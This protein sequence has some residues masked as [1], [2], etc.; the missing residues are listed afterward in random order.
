VN[1]AAL[2]GRAEHLADPFLQTLMRVADHQ[3]DAAQSTLR[4]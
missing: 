4:Q 1:G 3:L 2:P